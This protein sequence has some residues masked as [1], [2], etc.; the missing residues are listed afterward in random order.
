MNDSMPI[1]G[2]TR[3]AAV[4]RLLVLAHPVNVLLLQH[5]NGAWFLVNWKNSTVF[6]AMIFPLAEFVMEFP[7]L[8][9]IPGRSQQVWSSEN[10]FRFYIPE[11][12]QRFDVDPV[13]PCAKFARVLTPNKLC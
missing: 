11:T 13:L 10:I 3:P 1:V 5:F 9:R 12:S 2:D 4:E 8:Q 6:F 7:D